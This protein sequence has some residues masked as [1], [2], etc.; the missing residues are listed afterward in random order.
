MAQGRMWHL[1]KCLYGLNDAARHF[2]HSVVDELKALGCI[3]SS[4]DPAI[5]YKNGDNGELVGILMSHI[6]DFL[7]AGEILFDETVM[8][9]LRD[10]FLAGKLEENQFSYIGFHIK[11]IRSGIILDQNKYVDSIEI[12]TIS[13]ERS[14]QKHDDLSEK[15]S[16]M[17]RSLA[18]YINWIVHGS[19]PDLA[20]ELMDLSTKFNKAKIVDL[21]QALKAIRKVKNQ[22]SK[23]FFPNLGDH[24]SWRLL[25][26]TDAAHANLCDGV[27]SSM[28]FV[29]F[30]VGDGRQC[31]PLSWSANKIK[32]VVRSTLAAEALSLQEGM[33]EVIYIR[34]MMIELLGISEKS[35]PILA[36]VDNKS[37]VEAI[38]ST[39]MVDDKRLRIDIGAI[40]ESV[41]KGEIAKVRWVPG[42][43]QLANCLTKKGASG[44]QLLSVFQSGKIHLD[45]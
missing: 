2:Y 40:K 6:D 16:T 36:Y 24:S 22:D 33:E 21:L 9:G 29:I 43:S 3:Q 35:I 1:L 28:A 27:S 12:K 11:Q 10:R 26:F 30:L 17:Y 37:V 39:K 4:L 20:F 14:A 34:T 5:F 7:H 45:V 15:E 8:R 32:R 44:R 42:E 23:I 18:G 31:C 25:L 19:R 13:S 38:H 41:E